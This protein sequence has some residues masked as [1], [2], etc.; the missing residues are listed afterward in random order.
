MGRLIAGEDL[1]T[2]QRAIIGPDGTLIAQP[3]Q[4]I[5]FLAAEGITKGDEVVLDEVAP[6]AFL[7]FRK[8][9]P[10]PSPSSSA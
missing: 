6:G 10:I 3:P 2:N 1:L 8:R 5:P 9:Q 7:V 4:T